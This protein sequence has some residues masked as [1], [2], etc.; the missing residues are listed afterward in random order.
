LNLIVWKF[1]RGK[2]LLNVWIIKEIKRN[3]MP[4][5]RCELFYSVME[6][7]TIQE[8]FFLGWC[9]SYPFP[10]SFPIVG[11]SRSQSF[12]EAQT[13]V[14]PDIWVFHLSFE[15]LMNKKLSSIFSG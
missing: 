3:T 6:S 14:N 12:M 8:Q 4:V 9:N 10:W 15:L 1:E 11:P 5:K 7:D 13:A 2:F